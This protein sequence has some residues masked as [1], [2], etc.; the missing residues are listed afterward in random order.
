MTLTPGPPPTPPAR[1]PAA[2]RCR[3]RIRCRPR[4]SAQAG[5]RA[6]SAAVATTIRRAAGETNGPMPASTSAIRSRGGGSSS[7][8]STQCTITRARSHWVRNPSGRGW[9]SAATPGRS[10]TRWISSSSSTSGPKVGSRV[11]C[12]Y[13]A[14]TAAAPVRATSSALLPEFGNPTIADVDRQPQLERQP[15]GLAGRAGHG[16]AR[17]LVG[18]GPEDP[19][20]DP[21][22]AAAGDHDAIAGGAKVR[23]DRR[24]R[25]RCVCPAARGPPRRHRC[26]HGGPGAHRCRRLPPCGARRA[27]TATGRPPGGR[28]R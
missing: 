26:V 20:P 23:D 18:R 1:P 14:T 12:G 2:R 24:R 15:G 27:G 17:S 7:R 11:E 6:G 8:A 28:R 25:A 16:V 13:G 19:V 4:T 21:A 3:R 5:T 10:A 22:V 9:P